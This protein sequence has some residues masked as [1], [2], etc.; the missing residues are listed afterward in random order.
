MQIKVAFYFPDVTDPTSVEAKRIL[1]TLERDCNQLICR[2]NNDTDYA[3]IA[4]DDP[5]DEE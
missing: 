1:A 4:H 2:R 3:C 5:T